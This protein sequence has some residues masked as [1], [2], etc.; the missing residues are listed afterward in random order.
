MKV[1]ITND[2]GIY[3]PGLWALVKEFKKRGEVVVVAPDREQSAVGTA[4]TLHHPLRVQKVKPEIPGVE[5]YAIGGTPGDSV[6]IPSFVC[7]AL[8]NAIR[9]TGA[10]VQVADIQED[11]FMAAG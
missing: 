10:S 5:T 3:A 1:L 8:L 11:E 9:Y 6:I 2:D 4:I 7:T